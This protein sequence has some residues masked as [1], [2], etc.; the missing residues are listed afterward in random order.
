MRIERILLEDEGDVAAGRRHAG[1]VAAADRHAAG[2]RRLEPGDE[3]QRRRLAGAGRAEQH[4]E[5]A[6]RDGVA[7]I[8]CNS[9]TLRYDETTGR[10]APDL[11]SA[12]M[13]RFETGSGGS[14][15]YGTAKLKDGSRADFVCLFGTAG[16]L[17]DL[18]TSAPLI[19]R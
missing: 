15:L 14:S 3:P 2:I 17:K 12:E 6:V 10:F 4:D 19:D 8:T 1:H 13:T 11:K 9:Q 7:R 18:Q 16:K 5:F